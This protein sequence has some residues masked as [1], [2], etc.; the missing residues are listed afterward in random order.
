MIRGV[1]ENVRRLMEAHQWSQMTLAVRAKV[2]QKTISDLLNFGRTSNKSPTMTT[3]ARIAAAFGCPPWLL[4]VPEMPLDLLQNQRVP[5][6][7]EN[8]RDG[9]ER[10]RENVD[11]IA[12][13]EMHYHSVDKRKSG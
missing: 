2:S 7:V 11:R 9:T 12:E 5:K 13:S 1:A 6:L 4:Q 3:I 10:G 8:Y